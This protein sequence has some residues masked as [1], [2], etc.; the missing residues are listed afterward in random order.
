MSLDSSTPICCFPNLKKCLTDMGIQIGKAGVWRSVGTI[1]VLPEDIG[2]RIRL[3]NDG[4]FYVDSEGGRHRGFM[5][6]T[7]FSFSGGNRPKFHICKCATIANFGSCSYRFANAEP[8]RVYSYREY[9]DVYVSGL[10]LCGNCRRMLTSEEIRRIYDSTAFVRDLK[11]SASVDNYDKPDES[12]E[13]DVDLFGY[14]W[15]WPS[16]SRE[17]RAKRNFTCERC[18]TRVKDGFDH[19]FMHAHHRNGIK[20]DNRESNLECLCI[21]CHSE[22]DDAHRHNFSFGA[23]RFLIDEYMRKYHRK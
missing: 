4:I 20:T 18:G 17:F 3:E 12:D 22:V 13:S 9:K 8:V 1:D 6:K 14:V 21:K 16:I 15:N 23:Q 5:Y 19:T 2:D 11:D 7:H 10:E